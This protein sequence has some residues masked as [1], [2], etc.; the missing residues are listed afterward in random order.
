ML[1]G[2]V[3]GKRGPDTS[4]SGQ[5]LA[6]KPLR[7]AE[8]TRPAHT[9]QV[10]LSHAPASKPLRT[11]AASNAR[12][13]VAAVAFGEGRAGIA[14]LITTR[15]GL[16]GGVALVVIVIVLVEAAAP[17]SVVVAL[18]AEVL[19]DPFR[20]RVSRARPVS[21]GPCARPVVVFIKLNPATLV[22]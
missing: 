2:V 9:Q 3:V 16:F 22:L 19:C 6:S 20:A 14:V 21:T 18:D 8:V 12:A 15:S 1:D 5:N 10:P 13:I 4:S 11:G 7:T 17:P